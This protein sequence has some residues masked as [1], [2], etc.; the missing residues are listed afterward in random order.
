MQEKIEKNEMTTQQKKVI[1]SSAGVKRVIACAG[2][3]KTFV[4][5][6]S[7]IELLEK[8]VCRP[9][10]ILAITFTRNAA[11]NM[12]GNIRDKLSRDIDF[13]SIN[14]YTFN[15]FGNL[16]VSENSFALGLGKDYKLINTSKGIWEKKQ[17]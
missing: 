12:R 14:I 7:I 16:L 15:S 1:E 11:E 5:T 17:L 3:G 2:S 9:D 4:L 6:Q 8:R 13:E 10:E